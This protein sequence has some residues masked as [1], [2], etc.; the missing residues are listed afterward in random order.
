MVEA[1]AIE[2]C[3][4]FRINVYTR[5]VGASIYNLVETEAE[6]QEIESELRIWCSY[7]TSGENVEGRVTWQ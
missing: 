6:N 7:Y 3:R 4:E 2:V 5:K 1:W